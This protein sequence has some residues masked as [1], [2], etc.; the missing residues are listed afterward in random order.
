MSVS[1]RPQSS[2]KV[3][4][5][6][7]SCG[8]LPYGV[9]SYKVGILM[10]LPRGIRIDDCSS[11]AF[12]LEQIERKPTEEAYHKLVALIQHD[13]LLG[14]F[15][16]E[17]PSKKNTYPGFLQLESFK[18]QGKI[19]KAACLILALRCLAKRWPSHWAEIYA[20]VAKNVHH[21]LYSLLTDRQ[22]YGGSA[23]GRAEVT[24]FLEKHQKSAAELL[25]QRNITQGPRFQ[26]YTTAEKP[27]YN[28]LLGAAILELAFPLLTI[29]RVMPQDQ[30]TVE[31]L[32]SNQKSQ[33][34]KTDE[35]GSESSVVRANLL[36]APPIGQ[37]GQVEAPADFEDAIVSLLRGPSAAI[38]FRQLPINPEAP[39]YSFGLSEHNP[40]G[41]HYG[42]IT[43]HKRT[44]GGPNMTAASALWAAFGKIVVQRLGVDGSDS[45]LNRVVEEVDQYFFR[46]LDCLEG[47][48]WS[49]GYLTNYWSEAH[50]WRRSIERMIDGNSD[51]DYRVMLEWIKPLLMRQLIKGIER[52]R[53]S[54]SSAN[55]QLDWEEVRRQLGETATAQYY[56]ELAEG[57]LRFMGTT[58]YPRELVN[59]IQERIDQERWFESRLQPQINEREDEIKKIM[60]QVIECLRKEN[61][62]KNTDDEKAARDLIEKAVEGEDS[63]EESN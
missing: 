6:H 19:G 58:V 42:R 15:L 10:G 17:T 1:V 47:N 41:K 27:D 51:H 59:K 31:M 40:E 33:K 37:R 54:L 32:A 16:K 30:A 50:S 52:V 60:E 46:P 62:I 3:Y 11:L 21:Y 48:W 43:T 35:I 20:L 53:R 39:I 49:L 34:P 18:T 25:K 57:A 9:S 8:P 24:E 4:Q 13:E 45:A 14:Q 5:G 36:M 12:L 26:V 63:E 56:H 55:Q 61:L 28:N 44:S 23:V 29:C 22:V 38:T 7:R 2:P